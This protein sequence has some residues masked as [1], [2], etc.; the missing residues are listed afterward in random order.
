MFETDL[1]KVFITSNKNKKE[2][3]GIYHKKFKNKNKNVSNCDKKHQM[4]EVI[5]ADC[6]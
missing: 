4:Q 5:I 2:E 3:N 1:A 6:C